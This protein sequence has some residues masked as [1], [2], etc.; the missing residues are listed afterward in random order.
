MTQP[1]FRHNS[2][3]SRLFVAV[4]SAVLLSSALIIGWIGL[5]IMQDFQEKSVQQMEEGAGRLD[6]VLSQDLGQA[7]FFLESL[8]RQILYIGVED[9]EKIAALLRSFDTK[10]TPFSA[11]AWADAKQTILINSASG[12]MNQPIDVSDRDYI[13]RSL[14]QPWKLQIGRPIEGRISGKWVIP[15]AIGV[16][17]YTETHFGTLMLSLNLEHVT[18]QMRE[19]LAK[20]NIDFGVI[21]NNLVAV[22]ESASAADFVANY[23][24]L[25][26]LHDLNSLPHSGLFTAEQPTEENRYMRFYQ[27]SA[28]YPFV[29]LMGVDIQAQIWRLWKEWWWQIAPVLCVTIP[30]LIALWQL[31]KR[32]L[33]PLALLEQETERLIR[34][35]SL[36]ANLNTTPL[37]ICAIGEQLRQISGYIQERRRIEFEQKAKLTFLKRAK[38]MS[39]LSNRVKVDFLTSMSHEF[40]TP[41]NSI[42]G[43]VE[44]M[45]HEVYGVIGNERYKQ[46]LLDIHESVNALQSLVND[47]IALSKA[48]ST[49]AEI[50]EKPVEVQLVVARSIR[51]LAEKLKEAGVTVENRVQENIPKLR[52]D[53]GRLRQV[54]QNLLFNAL[55]HNAAGGSIVVD[56]K[57]SE[58][59]LHQPV[60]E[61]VI[62]DFGAKRLP[63]AQE[64]DDENFGIAKR[65][66]KALQQKVGNLGVPLTKALVAIQQATLEVESL[67]GK[68]TTI[69]VRYPKEKIVMS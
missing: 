57:I 13:K 58:D 39:D 23:F 43:F 3:F 8:S 15:L 30:A 5:G 36:A 62:T 24:P 46:Y 17:D 53:E 9:H 66:K 7:T 22:T 59:T 21:T 61:I 49:Q 2:S 44:L 6:Q 4:G 11:F 25:A 40:R 1:L 51:N 20:E 54:I 41:L 63:V 38:D 55:S 27:R 10:G 50:Y 52:V 56:A 68:P 45:L 26:G 60:F 47:V 12:K 28:S 33:H 16:T 67:P 64:N 14:I 69:T 37:E 31:R 29:F 18:G 32:V 48:E 34:G 35:E 65:K 19:A 42:T